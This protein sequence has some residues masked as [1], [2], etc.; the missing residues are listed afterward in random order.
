MRSFYESGVGDDVGGRLFSVLSPSA[1]KQEIDS[2][3][4]YVRRIDHDVQAHKGRVA[5]LLQD[6]H[7]FVEEWVAFRDGAGWFARTTGATYDKALDYRK[8]AD[9]WDEIIRRRG[10]STTPASTSPAPAPT[11]DLI[12]SVVKLAGIGVAA[13]A[14]VSLIQ[15]YRNRENRN[16]DRSGT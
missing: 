9:A 8:R 2:V 12:G 4:H 7:L 6:W 3:D 10:A 11:G 1:I 15:I 16:D 5:D 13:Y 14:G